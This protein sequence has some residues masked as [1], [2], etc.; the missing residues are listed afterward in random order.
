MDLMI[1][2]RGVARMREERWSRGV[3]DESFSKKN[4]LKQDTLKK[5]VKIGDR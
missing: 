1:I 2:V 5:N 4:G 3:F